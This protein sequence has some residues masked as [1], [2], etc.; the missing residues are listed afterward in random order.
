MRRSSTTA[1][2]G[3]AATAFRSSSPDAAWAVTCSPLLYKRAASATRM[4]LPPR[5][6]CRRRS[7]CPRRGAEDGEVTAQHADPIAQPGEAAAETALGT[8]GSIVGHLDA[9]PVTAIPDDD[10]RVG[11]ASVFDHVCQCLCQCL[12]N[13]EVRRRVPS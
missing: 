2:G 8:T 9:Q 13:K 3:S 11:C 4:T 10:S 5:S 6:E 7:G 12:A 1:S